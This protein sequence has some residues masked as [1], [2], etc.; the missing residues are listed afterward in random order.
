MILP[1]IEY[2]SLA[3]GTASITKLKKLDP[4]HHQALRICLGAFHTTPIES[5]YTETN[6]HSLS[7]RRKIVGIKYYART[8]TIPKQNTICTSYGYMILFLSVSFTG[9]YVGR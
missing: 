6:L 7:Y 3:Y 4:I 2:G 1:K 8:L 9:T 5:L